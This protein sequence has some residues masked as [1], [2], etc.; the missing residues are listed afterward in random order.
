MKTTRS[1]HADQSPVRIAYI[2]SSMPARWITFEW[3]STHLNPQKFDLSFVLIHDG[4]PPLAPFLKARQIPFIHIQYQGPFQLFQTLRR[5]YRYLRQHHIEVVHT[6]FRI[7]GLTGLLAAALA[8]VPHRI[9]TRHYGGMHLQETWKPW[10][11]IYAW[12]SNRCASQVIA[13]SDVVRQLLQQVDRVPHA[14]IVRIDHGFDLD[15]LQTANRD[16]TSQR[17]SPT[18]APVVGVIARYERCK[19]IQFVIPAFQRLLQDYPN[20][21]LVLANAYGS[22]A[23]EIRRLLKMLP[24]HSYTEIQFEPSLVRLYRPLDVFVHTPTDIHYEA[25]GQVYIEALAA[26]VPAVI[27]PAGIASEFIIDRGNA[28][29][30][31][32][33]DSEAIYRSITAILTNPIH[34]AELIANGLASVQTR[35]GLDKMVSSLETLYMQLTRDPTSEA[36]SSIKWL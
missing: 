22:Y 16:R 11:T 21:K 20:A 33:Q 28:H 7:A 18:D 25:F 27:T 2:I 19:G 26:G 9:Y 1:E 23:H 31:P 36:P 10:Y 14:K 4:P 12:L 32:V 34:R 30:V 8:G 5:I 13:P 35:F 17:F 3:T 29:L 6:H 15:L 24:D